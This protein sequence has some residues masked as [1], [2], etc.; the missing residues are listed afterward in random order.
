M[1]VPYFT[2][3]Q[4]PYEVASGFTEGVEVQLVDG[5]Q[6]QLTDGVASRLAVDGASR[7]ADGVQ[8]QLEDGVQVQ[9][10]DGAT[11]FT[12]TSGGEKRQEKRKQI[13]NDLFHSYLN[14]TNKLLYQQEPQRHNEGYSIVQWQHLCTICSQL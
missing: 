10:A 12:S 11:T 1:T 2:A 4:I 9:M 6:V 7:L 3:S 5:V 8:V 13:A 14:Q